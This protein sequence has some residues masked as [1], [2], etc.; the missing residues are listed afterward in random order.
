ME[1]V[2]ICCQLKEF[3]E[4]Y[5]FVLA[6]SVSSALQLVC[7][8]QLEQRSEV[9]LHQRR[10]TKLC[11]TRRCTHL[12]HSLRQLPSDGSSTDSPP[13]LMSSTRRSRSNFVPSSAASPWSRAP[14]LSSPSS[15]P[16]SS[17]PLDRSSL[18]ISSFKVYENYTRYP[19]SDNNPFWCLSLLHP[20][21]TSSETS[22]VN[23]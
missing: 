22:W 6:C 10:S 17:Y 5:T 4:T 7:W 16:T 3:F 19:M 1:L 21:T 8:A 20:N 2:Q 9:Q 13:T 14:S 12:S 18:S 15:H 11:L 23:R